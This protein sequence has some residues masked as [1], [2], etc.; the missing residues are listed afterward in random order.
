MRLF[1]IYLG[2]GD[3]KVYFG[4]KEGSMDLYIVTLPEGEDGKHLVHVN[5]CTHAPSREHQGVLGLHSNC[6]AAIKEAGIIRDN[7]EM[8]GCSY[9]CPDCH[10]G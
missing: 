3:L 8:N 4:S 7:W 9:C 10:R 1:S 5:T 2:S 6:K